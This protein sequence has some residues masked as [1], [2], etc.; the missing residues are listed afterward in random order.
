MWFLFAGKVHSVCRW[1]FLSS[2]A[3]RTLFYLQDFALQVLKGL[4]CVLWH[5]ICP[6]SVSLQKTFGLNIWTAHRNAF[7]MTIFKC[8][9][10]PAD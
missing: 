9:R 4:I 2:G 1:V 7:I 5:I 8:T 3:A 6:C 10:P